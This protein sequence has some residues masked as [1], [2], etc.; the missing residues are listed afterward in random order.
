MSHRIVG[1]EHQCL[2]EQAQRLQQW[3]PR[4]R[5]EMRAR[6]EL[7]EIGLCRARA[8]AAE[9]LIH[10]RHLW[11]RGRDPG[12]DRILQGDT[13]HL[14]LLETLA[15]LGAAAFHVDQTRRDME[16][17][18]L[19][20]HSPLEH[21]R[22]PEGARTG[23]IVHGA[24]RRDGKPWQAPQHRA[25]RIG[26]ADPEI[27]V[28]F[29]QVASREGLH[30][31][32]HG[33]GHLRLAGIPRRLVGPGQGPHRHGQAIACPGDRLDDVR[34]IGS[35]RLAQGR[36]VDGE[37]AVLDHD[38]GPEPGPERLVRHQSATGLGQQQEDLPGLAGNGYAR[39]PAR[40]S[41]RSAGCR[42][43]GPNT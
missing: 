14:G 28:G 19:A 41:R 25:D 24:D 20:P 38:V 33:A 8:V 30:R 11:E 23:E 34:R 16:L 15:P 10:G 43:N 7:Q 22:Q 39:R 1:I 37:R 12:G 29:G 2:L 4:E 36:H 27:G 32:R 9:A 3:Q 42:A 5:H 31:E 6:L 40:V 26:N 13:I 18:G 21:V 35:E 17:F